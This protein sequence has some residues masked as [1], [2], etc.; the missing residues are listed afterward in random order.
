[1]LNSIL[2][3]LKRTLKTKQFYFVLAVIACITFV[4]C[5]IIQI[6]TNPIGDEPASLALSSVS[7][8]MILKNFFTLPIYPLVLALYVTSFCTKDFENRF[9]LNVVSYIKDKGHYA[10]TKFIS[11]SVISAIL[12]V[13]ICIC[14]YL[15]GMSLI[16]PSAVRILDP[17]VDLEVLGIEFIINEFL[18]A[19]YIL[20]AVIA[21]KSSIASMS[22]IIVVSFLPQAYMLLDNYIPFAIEDYS[23][24]A[25]MSSVGVVPNPEWLKLIGLCTIYTLVMLIASVLV[26][27]KKDL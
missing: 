1:M 12:M 17:I 11:M 21:R 13:F 3:D 22:A 23:V 14:C 24:I 19:F 27:R 7:F 5:L 20:I 4:V 25:N 10:I 26:M 16:D 9:V 15:M 2:M 18:I 6:A 8:K